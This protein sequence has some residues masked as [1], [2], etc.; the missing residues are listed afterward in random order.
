MSRNHPCKI[1][2]HGTNYLSCIAIFLSLPFSHSVWP[3]ALCFQVVHPSVLPIHVNAISHEQLRYVSQRSKGQAH[4]T[5]H[6]FE[7]NLSG[8]SKGNIITCGT[9]IHLDSM[10]T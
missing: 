9:N 3:E 5:L 7:Y 8:L 6:C 1:K 2:E 10:M 4:M